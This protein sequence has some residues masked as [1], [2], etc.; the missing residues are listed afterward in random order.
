[1]SSPDQLMNSHT[2]IY[3][4]NFEE[5][6]T[7]ENWSPLHDSKSNIIWEGHGALSNIL[8]DE[9]KQPQVTGKLNLS[10]STSPYDYFIEVLI[11]LH[12][13]NIY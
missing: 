13:V 12:P 8:N 9:Q 3:S 11:Q 4:A 6:V 1:M 2:A 10:D 5:S 7:V